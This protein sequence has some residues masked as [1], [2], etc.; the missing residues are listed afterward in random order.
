MKQTLLISLLAVFFGTTCFAQ[1][2]L[3]QVKNEKVSYLTLSLSQVKEPLQ[4]FETITKYRQA[5]R[6]NPNDAVALFQL[7]R[8]L[9]R[10]KNYDEAVIAFNKALEI[11]PDFVEASLYL[12]LTYR[13]LDMLD[14]ARVTNK[15][16]IDRLKQI[17]MAYPD[18]ILP[19]I[20]LY[21]TFD[22]YSMGD[23]LI[24][25]SWSF[26][27]DQDML[28]FTGS[29]VDRLVPWDKYDTNSLKPDNFYK[30]VIGINTNNAEAHYRL[31]DHLSSMARTGNTG[32]AQV[33]Y[34][35][36]VQYD[37][38]LLEAHLC[39]CK[40]YYDEKSDYY[41][42]ELKSFKKGFNTENLQAESWNDLGRIYEVFKIYS[43]ARDAFKRAI[44]LDN[45]CAEAHYNLGMAGDKNSIKE[46]KQAITI[47]PNF[48]AA[49]L[50]LGLYYIGIDKKLALDEYNILKNLDSY[51]AERLYKQL[52]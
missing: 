16:A 21:A 43:E 18:S 10:I 19:K 11:S 2:T 14:K 22:H 1:D 7:G 49:H 41:K 42:N 33:E 8:V 36:A 17:G 9:Y 4:M 40:G 39:I 52:Y 51:K 46:F 13:G 45:N 23:S 25:L 24:I 48:A 5:I 34:N 31:A 26:K 35:L 27:N 44:K 20:Y 15:T 32:I 30:Q 38:Q 6:T 29:W 37:P 47:N 50:A 12:A 28:L 3:T